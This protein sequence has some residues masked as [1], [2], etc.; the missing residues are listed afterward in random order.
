MVTPVSL[1]RCVDAEWHYSTIDLAFISDVQFYKGL[2]DATPRIYFDRK[3]EERKYVVNL[4]AINRL[5]KENFCTDLIEKDSQTLMKMLITCYE[6]LLQ[7]SRLVHLAYDNKAM[8][9]YHVH[10]T[11]CSESLRARHKADL[12]LAY[13]HLRKTIRA[14]MGPCVLLVET[15]Q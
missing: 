8:S 13:F 10:L 1:K 9:V 11:G 7:H 2:E 3:A 15:F 4:D 12:K 6:T 14:F 5:V